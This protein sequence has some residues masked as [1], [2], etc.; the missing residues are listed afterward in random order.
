M[1]SLRGVAIELRMRG[2]G[3]PGSR[4]AVTKPGCLLKPGSALQGALTSA[5]RLSLSP[6]AQP[7][8]LLREDS[9]EAAIHRGDDPAGLGGG[10]VPDHTG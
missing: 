9:R 1:V 10:A 6:K 3:G 4:A 2:L 5:R 7:Y 8:F